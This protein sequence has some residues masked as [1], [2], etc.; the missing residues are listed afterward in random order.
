NSRSLFE[1][2]WG[3]LT[4][5]FACT[6]VLVHPNLPPPNQ[7]RLV[8][9][10]N[11]LKMMLIAIIAP[12]IMVGFAARQFL[13]ARR[14]SKKFES[15]GASI[16]LTHG[17]FISMGGFVSQNGHPI[18][19]SQQLVNPE[20]VSAIQN[21]KVEDIRDKSKGD[22]LSKAVALSQGLWF[23]TQCVARVSQH[24]PVTEL[25]VTTLAF[26]VVNIFIWLLWWAKP[27]DAE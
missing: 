7:C 17:F 2:I 16:T 12:E 8:L 14:F 19:T 22:V 3:C 26:A 5:I 21:V 27:L 24:L 10:W 20:Y 18:A 11:R 1:I 23:I 4:T 25:E 13:A 15:Q 9:S 6:W